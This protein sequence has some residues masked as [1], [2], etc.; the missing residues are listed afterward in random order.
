MPIIITWFAGK[1]YSPPN[2]Y[3]PADPFSR[4]PR[5]GGAIFL[6]GPFSAVQGKEH[7]V[8]NKNRFIQVIFT[9]IITILSTDFQPPPPSTT[10]RDREGRKSSFPSYH[11][12]RRYLS[13]FLSHETCLNM[14][15]IGKSTFSQPVYKSLWEPDTL[16]SSL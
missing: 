11:L 8:S 6:P 13:R 1:H 14:R 7:F 2:E 12:Y 10:L 9:K 16:R 3:F 5:L 15:G 4:L